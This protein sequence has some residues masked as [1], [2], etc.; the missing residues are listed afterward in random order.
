MPVTPRTTRRQIPNAEIA[1]LLREVAELLELERANAFRV[2]AYSNAA[3]VIEEL[4]E[5]A[6][7]LSQDRL[8]ELPGIGD[9]L[10]AKIAEI[11]AKGSLGMLRELRREVPHAALEFLSIPGIGPARARQLVDTLGLRSVAGLARAARAGRL[12]TLPG[13][14]AALESKIIRELAARSGE[15]KRILRAT[16]AQYGE[17]LLEYMRAQPGVRRAD[18]AGSFRRG[19][20]TVGDLDVLVEAS[21]GAEASAR[22]VRYPGVRSVLAQGPTR[23]SVRLASGLQVD[24]R[25]LAAESY[26]AGL[27]YFTGSKAHNIAVRTIG[28]RR[29]LKINEYGVF[30]GERRIGGRVEQ[31]VFDAVGLPWIPPELREDR[32]ELEAA[33]RRKLPRLV[34][35]GDIRGDLHLHSTDSDGRDTLDAMAESAQELGYEYIAITDHTPMLRV[36]NGLDRARFLRQ[37]KRIER[38]NGRLRKLTVLAGAEVD[39][40]LDGSLDLDDETLA[41]LDVV[42]V[43]LHSHF[44]LP[45]ARQTER[46]L[47]AIRH[48]AVDIFAHPTGRLI[49]QRRGADFDLAR[50][51]GEA[52][53]RGVML[54]VNAQPTRLD[55]DDLSCRAA[56]ARGATIAINTDAHSVSELRQLRW[57][58]DQARRGWAARSD[59]ANT[60]SLTSLSKLLHG[61][62]R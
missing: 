14:G 52:A 25:A 20:D 12:R 4:P 1:R 34:E 3:R 36:V 31:D 55:L 33:V 18:I 58:V 6:A 5:P 61:R 42:L 43:S 26:G 22:F 7:S 40:L 27:Y 19:R 50:V 48:P 10:A 49:G 17:A 38:L 29:G 23:A 37:R 62:R 54:E 56:I 41:S 9:D 24:F 46:V 32:G 39:I 60:R 47:R 35:Q 15:A 16:A 44:D 53:D 13:F 11:S 28:R 45:R 59:V 30:K 2:R 8:R 21:R 57:G 51:A